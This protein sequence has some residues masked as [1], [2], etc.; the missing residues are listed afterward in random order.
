VRLQQPIRNAL[1]ELGEDEDP[2]RVIVPLALKSRD[3]Q[4]S[5]TL[6]RGVTRF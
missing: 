2:V 6:T 1:V 4:I 3:L 5:P